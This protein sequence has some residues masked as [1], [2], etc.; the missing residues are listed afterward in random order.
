MLTPCQLFQ[1]VSQSDIC[2]ISFDL[3]L[4]Q[5]SESSYIYDVRVV[6]Y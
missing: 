4:L 1:P 5:K 2:T 3:F 6:E